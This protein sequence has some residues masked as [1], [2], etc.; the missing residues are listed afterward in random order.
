MFTNYVYVL[1]QTDKR[2]TSSM[3]LYFDKKAVMKALVRS[4]IL[5]KSAFNVHVFTTDNVKEA[6]LRLYKHI[7]MQKD[8]NGH[9][10]LWLKKAFLDYSKDDV[11]DEPEMFFDTLEEL[12]VNECS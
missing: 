11:M 10:M 4:V 5:S 1:T 2:D 3:Q 9:Y 7:K 8:S 6:P 12:D